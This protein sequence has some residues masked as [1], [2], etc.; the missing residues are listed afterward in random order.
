V[1]YNGKNGQLQEQ[2]ENWVKNTLR[3]TLAGSTQRWVC[4]TPEKTVLLKS[5][6]GVKICQR[7]ENDGMGVS[8][9]AQKKSSFIARPEE[10]L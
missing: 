10:R 7:V 1:D 2:S 6:K 4:R 3:G 9:S 5:L 8:V